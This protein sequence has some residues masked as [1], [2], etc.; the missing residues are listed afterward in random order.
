M[1]EDELDKIL[2]KKLEDKS[3]ENQEC[4][5][6][7]CDFYK[8]LI[9]FRAESYNWQI[10]NMVF[11]INLNC[12][13]FNLKVINENRMKNCFYWKYDSNLC[14]AATIRFYE[15]GP[16]VQLFP[17]G[18]ATLL[19]IKNLLDLLECLFA[20]EAFVA[21][22]GFF[23]STSE[24]KCINICAYVK[25]PFKINIERLVRAKLPN[26][27]YNNEITSI[28]KYHSPYTNLIISICRRGTVYTTGMKY[29]EDYQS[30][31]HN[32]LNILKEF[33]VT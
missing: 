2:D 30:D 16:T 13:N 25:L 7:I 5:N 1:Y 28:P 9:A 33:F 20:L 17:K 12:Y 24:I 3:H 10:N 26:F 31:L 21:K 14:N 15:G 8:N 27:W 11:T 22:H 29:G 32:L 18:R 4:F 19:G 23:C 6:N